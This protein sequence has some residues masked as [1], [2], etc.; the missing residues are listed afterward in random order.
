MLLRH[1]HDFHGDPKPYECEHCGRGFFKEGDKI[2]HFSKHCEKH[3]RD[4]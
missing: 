2:R 3:H 1:R 4:I